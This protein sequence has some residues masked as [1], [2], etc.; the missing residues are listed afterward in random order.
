MGQVLVLSAWCI[1]T[2][3]SG[4]TD[5]KLTRSGLSIHRTV[6]PPANMLAIAEPTNNKYRGHDTPAGMMDATFLVPFSL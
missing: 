3:A 4:N 2:H 1:T 5:N 6:A